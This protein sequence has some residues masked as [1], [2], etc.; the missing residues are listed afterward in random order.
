MP[1][2]ASELASLFAR[3]IDRAG[4][5]L[6]AIDDAHLWQVVPGV[7]N[8]A[9]NLL[10]HLNGNLREYIGRQL[11]GVPYHRDR[12]REFAARDVPRAELTRALRELEALIPGVLGRVGEEQWDAPFPENVLGEPLTNRQFVIH[13]FGHLGYHLGQVDYIR[14]VLTGDGAIAPRPLRPAEPRG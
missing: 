12:A 9:G 13:L 1:S 4:R 10:L 2:T 11:G 14:R 7:T 8:S 6:D 5:Q 3:D